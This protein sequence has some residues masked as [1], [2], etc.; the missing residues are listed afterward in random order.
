MKKIKKGTVRSIPAQTK[1]TSA[2]GN[3]KV[4]QNRLKVKSNEP[5]N[6]VI[7]P[8]GSEKNTVFSS[9]LLEIRVN[10]K[11]CNLNPN[12]GDLGYSYETDKQT[13]LIK[14]Y[15]VHNASVIENK[16]EI[17]MKLMESALTISDFKFTVK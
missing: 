1:I 11:I 15:Q 7:E 17:E 5:I 13:K 14:N 3:I 16:I 4:Y 8:L 6:I 9:R 2:K 10:K 12:E